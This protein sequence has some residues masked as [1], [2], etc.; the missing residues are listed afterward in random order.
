MR[1]RR[2]H[3]VGTAR[4]GALGTAI[5]L[6]ALVVMAAFLPAPSQ[7]AEAAV[8]VDAGAAVLGISPTSISRSTPRSAGHSSFPVR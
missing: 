3:R 8:G 7:P 2:K 4:A 6:G 1:L 5:A